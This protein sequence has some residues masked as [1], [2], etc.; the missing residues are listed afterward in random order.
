MQDIYVSDQYAE[1]NP[2]WHEEDSPWKARQ[3]EEIIRKNGLRFETLCEVGCGT[4]EILLNLSRSFPKAQFAGYEISPHAYQRAKTKEKSNVSFHLANI[5]EEKDSHHDVVVIADV[6]EHVEDYISFIKNLRPCGRYKI[7]HI[8][9]DLSVQSVL[10]AWP[11]TKLRANVGHLHYFFKDTAIATL[12]DCGYSV[13]DYKY[14]AS[15]LELPNQ[16]FTSALMRLPRKLLFSI[17]PDSAV[18]LL[19]GYSLLVLAE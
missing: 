14:T 15:R 10:R 4:G 6:I 18:R 17:N 16:A 13:I 1:L 11:I 2:T 7:F 19:G 9:L 12:K 8:P 5:V 3:I